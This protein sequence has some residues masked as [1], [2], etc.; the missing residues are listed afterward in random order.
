MSIQSR[1]VA[2]NGGSPCRGACARQRQP[3][4]IIRMDKSSTPPDRG[5]A[6]FA[7]GAAA[8]VQRRAKPPCST[9]RASPSI[10]RLAAGLGTTGRAPVKHPMSRYRDVLPVRST[11]AH[12]PASQG[13]FATSPV[14][15]LLARERE[16]K[17]RLLRPYQ[18]L[19]RGGK[20]AR[21]SGRGPTPAALEARQDP[22]R[23]L[24][25]SREAANPIAHAFW[26]RSSA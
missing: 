4:H 5:S 26:A 2:L 15:T 12:A 20:L 16:R 6:G 19:P 25:D 13:W 21:C 10:P 3:P 22:S 17:H 24:P 14:A 1:P 8:T 11:V 23:N 9:R 7:P 18:T